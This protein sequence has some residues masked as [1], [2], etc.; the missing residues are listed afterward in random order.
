MNNSTRSLSKPVECMMNCASCVLDGIYN[1]LKFMNSLTLT[2]IVISGK[3][4]C[5]SAKQVKE[6]LGK[7]HTTFSILSF[8]T[9]I[10]FGLLKLVVVA[11]SLVFSLAVWNL[12]AEK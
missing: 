12:G 2:Q 6:L 10:L 9:G 7:K 4:Y 5:Q 3:N 8:T 1:Y 11:L